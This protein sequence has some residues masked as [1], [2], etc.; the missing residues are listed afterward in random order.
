MEFENQY[1]QYSEYIELGG[2]L[3]EMPFNILEFEARK[4]IDERTQRRLL[5]VSDIPQE[6]KMCMYKLIN[7]LDV[8][9]RTQEKGN[10]SSESI[11][12][13]SVSYRDVS[14][15]T[16][17]AK[18]IELDNI[19]TTYLINTVVNNTHILYLGVI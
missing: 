11:D 3:T 6:I 15:T 1:L 10:I 16:T 18:N 7:T 5:N 8:Y 2:T 12:G 4:K 19:I 13:Y 9:N 17:Q 14:Q